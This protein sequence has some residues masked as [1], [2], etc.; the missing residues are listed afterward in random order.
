MNRHVKIS[1]HANYELIWFWESLVFDIFTSGVRGCHQKC[2]HFSV[3]LAPH[4]T[5]IVHKMSEAG[6][7]DIKSCSLQVLCACEAA[8]LTPHVGAVAQ[9]PDEADGDVRRRVI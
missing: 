9:L 2:E 1:L 5:Q 6:S 7:Y 8:S 3:G 4:V